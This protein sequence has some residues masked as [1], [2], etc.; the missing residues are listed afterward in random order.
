[1]LNL[2]V[3]SYNDPEMFSL[4]GYSNIV[5]CTLISY[6]NFTYN[7]WY[8]LHDNIFILTFSINKILQY[9]FDKTNNIN[10][11]CKFIVDELFVLNLNEYNCTIEFN[12]NTYTMNSLDN[13]FDMI[14]KQFNG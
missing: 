6:N 5:K 8:N 1:M 14:M 3:D 9:I 10:E 13:L 11:A 4:C 7:I 12:D 2:D